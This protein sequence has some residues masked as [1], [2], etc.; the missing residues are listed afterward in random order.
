M[1]VKIHTKGIRGSS[2]VEEGD[3]PSVMFGA[4]LEIDG[5][6]LEQADRVEVLFEDGFAIVT[7]RMIPAS[8]EIVSHTQE[9]WPGVED[10]IDEAR[11]ARTGMGA[12]IAMR[13]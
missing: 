6:I 3:E 7:A 1:R 4:V 9:S 10:A 13:R 2:I 11:T 5:K 8:I 12:A